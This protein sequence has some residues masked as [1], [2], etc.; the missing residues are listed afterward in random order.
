MMKGAQ[1]FPQI[2]GNHL[3]SAVEIN[4]SLPTRQSSYVERSR[5]ERG[6]VDS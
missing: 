6:I 5:I 2:G 4:L 3:G 1:L